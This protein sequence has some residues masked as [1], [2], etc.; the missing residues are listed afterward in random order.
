MQDV[1]RK[2]KVPLK[3]SQYHG[4]LQLQWKLKVLHDPKYVIPREVWYCS[5]FRSFRISSINRRNSC[6]NT[7]TNSK[8]KN[9]VITI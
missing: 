9:M 7:N 3:R 6:S 8:N 4:S 2:A 1:A 5:M